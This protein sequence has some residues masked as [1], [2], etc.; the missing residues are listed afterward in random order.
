[1]RALAA[2]RPVFHSEADFQ[3][4]LAWEVQ[5]SLPRAAV[6]L[7]RPVKVPDRIK[8]LHVDVWI[9]QEGEAIVIELKYKT[10][11]LQASERGELFLVQNHGAQDLGRYDFI[12]DIWRAET[13]VEHST[14][15][16]GHAVMLTN[17]PSYW[18]PPRNSHTVDSE[19]R[20]HD[21][22]ELQGSLNWGAHAG[23]GTMRGRE[24]PLGLSGSYLLRWKDYSQTRAEKHAR[25]RYLHVEIN[26]RE[27]QPG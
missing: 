4:A 18:S 15:V 10:R 13:V 25:F 14:R 22:R 17:D 3:H 5:R 9:E 26:G 24:E 12:K 2:H 6:R 23:E 8:P 19:F 16:V 11:I 7:E 1:M 27:E 20:L 21:G